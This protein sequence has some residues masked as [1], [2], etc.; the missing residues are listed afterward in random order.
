VKLTWAARKR[1][2]SLPGTV[3]P[4]TPCI[5]AARVIVSDIPGTGGMEG[6]THSHGMRLRHKGNKLQQPAP[7]RLQ[8]SYPLQPDL[9]SQ[10]TAYTIACV[11]K[12]GMCRINGYAFHDRRCHARLAV[13]PVSQPLQRPEDQRVM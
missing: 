9:F 11:V 2:S 6:F 7:Q 4:L 8:H 3:C 13:A 12:T 1:I 5:E 10:N